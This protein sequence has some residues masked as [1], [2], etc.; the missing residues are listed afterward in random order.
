MSCFFKVAELQ[1]SSKNQ[2]ARNIKIEAEWIQR[3][4][5]LW[6]FILPEK[7]GF[8]N[9]FFGYLIKKR[10]VLLSMWLRKKT[11]T[12]LTKTIAVAERKLFE[13]NGEK[14]ILYHWIQHEI[15][16]YP[17]IAKLKMFEK[18]R[19]KWSKNFNEGERWCNRI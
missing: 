11:K 15:L 9:A 8:T 3:N 4:R 2:H 16:G 12:H 7:K 1:G 6:N 18:D 5:L 17:I 10:E 14:I 13:K 19:L